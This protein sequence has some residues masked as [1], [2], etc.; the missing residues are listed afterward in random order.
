MKGMRLDLERV[1]DQLDGLGRMGSGE[2]PLLMV[3][4]NARWATPRGSR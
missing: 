2:W 3:I 4:D 1:L